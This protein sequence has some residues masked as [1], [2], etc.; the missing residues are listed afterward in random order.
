[1]YQRLEIKIL[2]VNFILFIKIIFS[3][4]LQGVLMG[5]LIALVE[6]EEYRTIHRTFELAASNHCK[7]A[8]QLG[9][10]YNLQTMCKLKIIFCS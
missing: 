2:F 7:I 10:Y 8:T 9:I 5:Y 1:M 4:F 3:E 6:L